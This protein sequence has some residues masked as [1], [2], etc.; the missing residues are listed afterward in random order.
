MI[1]NN[2]D[3]AG[4]RSNAAEE[5]PST[6]AESLLN[7]VTPT[8][9]VDLPSKGKG[10]PAGHPLHGQETVEIKYMT[11]KD[12]DI[13]TSK[14]LLK[15][16]VAIDRLIQN[17]LVDKN[18]RASDM[19]LGDRNAVIINARASGFGHLY[20]TNVKCPACGAGNKRTFDLTQPVVYNGDDWDDF[21]IVETDRGTY[22]FTLPSTNFK[23]EVR[24]LKGRDEKEIFKMVQSA[25]GETAMVTKQLRMYIV[26]V[27]GHTNP[28]II[29][30]FVE[31]IPMSQTN[32][33]KDAYKAISPDLKIMRDFECDSCMHEQELEVSLGTDFFWPN[34]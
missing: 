5:V 1:R 27:E 12:E 13:L 19:L 6:D 21:D 26:S 9:F 3:R 31:S 29:K 33:I 8:E 16:G 30:H 7:F 32:H 24:L 10:Y 22:I 11:A 20:N 28:N 23:V 15:K 4:P 17:L 2:S 14:D 25:K 34:R 18:I